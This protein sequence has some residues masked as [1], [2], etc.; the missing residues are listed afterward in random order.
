M[1]IIKLLVNH[2]LADVIK[3]I[4]SAV[5]QNIKYH[6]A[7]SSVFQHSVALA[8]AESY[9]RVI[10]VEKLLSSY[11]EIEIDL[12]EINDSSPKFSPRNSSPAFTYFHHL[13]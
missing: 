2:T 10:S 5:R 1:N 6:K 11:L 7:L 12:P 8:A 13:G 9:K 4:V 3:I